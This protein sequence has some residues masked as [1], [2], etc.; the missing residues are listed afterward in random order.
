MIPVAKPEMTKHDAQAVAD[1]VSSGWILQGP[2]VTEFEKKLRKYI[3]TRYSVATSSCTTAMHMGL[4]ACGIGPGDEVIVPSLSFIASPNCIV[5]AGATPV[6]ADIDPKTYNVDP[7]D[8]ERKITKKTK[9]ILV[10]HQIGLAADMD[11]FMRL[12]KKHNLLIL[13]DAACGL[14]A[15]INGRHVGTFGT[16][17]AFSFHPRKAITTAEGGML[18]TNSKRIAD[19]VTKLRS[20]GANLSVSARHTSKKVLFEHYPLI[21]YNYRMSDIHAALG[22]S[23]FAR[24]KQLFDKRQH[25]AARYTKAFSSIESIIPPFVP[26]GFHH[27]YQSYMIRISGGTSIRNHVMQQLLDHGIATRAGVMASHLEKPYR[28][29]YPNLHLPI[30]EQVAKETIILPLFAQ[31]THKEQDY[32]I[33]ELKKTLKNFLH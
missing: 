28:A 12:T 29:I 18:V 24:I 20:H 25:L 13:E 27:T 19:T 11:A 30:T 31:M 9:A 5:H 17:A 6:F 33:D 7:A 8:V 32:V 4:I 21:G 14:G 10:V 26:K 23:Q 3:G 15:T 1:V 22:L 2:K 16:W